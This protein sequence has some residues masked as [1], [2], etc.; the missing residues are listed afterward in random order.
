MAFDITELMGTLSADGYQKSSAL[1]TS[2][3]LPAA[4][5][6]TPI[7]SNVPFR[8]NSANLPGFQIQVDEF[9]HK[10]YG[11]T[12]KRPLQMTYD[13][14]T[15][16]I[17]ADGNGGVIEAFHKWMELVFPTDNTDGSDNV[18]YFEYP[19]NYYGGLEIYVYDIVGKKHTTYTFNQ[20]F[21]INIGGIQMS[22][23]DANAIVSIPITFAYR[24]YKKNSSHSGAI[25]KLAGVTT[26]A[27]IETVLNV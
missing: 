5:S 1:A 25:T 24:G 8:T 21:P 18:E 17:I 20:P 2:I 7:M 6:N 27:N 15:V 14:I 4:L 13:D 3:V 19:N 22:W 9:R 26:P 16:T 11:L 23:E 12:E 10:G